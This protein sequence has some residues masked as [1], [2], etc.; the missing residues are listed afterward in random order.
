MMY[1][2]KIVQEMKQFRRD[3]K[4][5]V[6]S[7]SDWKKFD[8]GLARLEKLLPAVPYW[9]D[10]WIRCGDCERVLGRYSNQESVMQRV[11]CCPR[12]GRRVDWN[13]LRVTK[14]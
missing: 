8:R 10:D 4:P 5:F 12:C 2:E 14:C 13:F 6:G 7:A 11:K 9:Y 3:F 1:E